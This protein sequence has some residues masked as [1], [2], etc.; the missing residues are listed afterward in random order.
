MSLNDKLSDVKHVTK[1]LGFAG[2]LHRALQDDGEPG[3]VES[4]EEEHVLVA[5]QA[6]KKRDAGLEA[7]MPPPN[8][9]SCDEVIIMICSRPFV[10]TSG[11]PNV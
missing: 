11:N 2:E 3:H 7:A 6:S 8:E 10:P 5:V 1:L 9:G 4:S